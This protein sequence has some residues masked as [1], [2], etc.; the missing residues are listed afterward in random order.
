VVYGRLHQHTP[1]MIHDG[2]VMQTM[3]GPYVDVHRIELA[4]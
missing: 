1:E 3:I 2:I 4:P